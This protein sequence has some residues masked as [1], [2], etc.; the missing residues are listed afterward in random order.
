MSLQNYTQFIRESALIEMMRLDQESGLYEGSSTEA[1][2][3]HSITQCGQDAAQNFIDDY[4]IDSEKLIAYLKQNINSPKK[5]DIRDLIKDP[6]S[7]KMLLKQFTNEKIEYPECVNIKEDYSDKIDRVESNA[8][9]FIKNPALKKYITDNDQYGFA[10]MEV[11]VAKLEAAMK[12]KIKDILA[13][14]GETLSISL[15]PTAKTVDI[16]LDRVG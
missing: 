9:L 4:N 2:R 10:I 1:Y 8:A 3:I 16:I 15:D 12:T 6:K 11:P 14:S 13:M 5:Y 7:N